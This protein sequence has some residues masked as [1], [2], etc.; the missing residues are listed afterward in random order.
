MEL[1]GGLRVS[2]KGWNGTWQKVL[3]K[4]LGKTEAQ[5]WDAQYDTDLKMTVV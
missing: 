3:Q 5:P 2:M 4:V 1:C